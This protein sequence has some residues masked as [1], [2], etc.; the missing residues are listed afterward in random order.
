LIVRE[1]VKHKIFDE[2]QLGLLN[3]IKSTEADEDNIFLPL[4]GQEA[5]RIHT[6]SKNILANLQEFF[7]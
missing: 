3:I 7:D 2:I 6:M 5:E 4:S 1:Q